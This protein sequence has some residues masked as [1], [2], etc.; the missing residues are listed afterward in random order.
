M[1]Q[2]STKFKVLSSDVKKSDDVFNK[3]VHVQ[4]VLSGQE[5]LLVCSHL[6]H[7]PVELVDQADW[8]AG[9]YTLPNAPTEKLVLG[10]H[11]QQQIEWDINKGE[12]TIVLT[13]TALIDDG[14]STSF[15]IRQVWV[16]KL[17]KRQVSKVNAIVRLLNLA[18]AEGWE[19][20]WV[21]YRYCD[22]SSN[23]EVLDLR[24][25]ILQSLLKDYVFYK[26]E[27]LT[28]FLYEMAEYAHVEIEEYDAV[29][30]EQVALAPPAYVIPQPA[31][32]Q[33]LAVEAQSVASLALSIA[34]TVAAIPV[35]F[36]GFW[37]VMVVG[38]NTYVSG[39]NIIHGRPVLEH[40]MFDRSQA[41][42]PDEA[43]DLGYDER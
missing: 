3:L 35:A 38:M 28:S 5:G 37:A 30:L 6:S 12:G 31:H 32:T 17:L 27:D 29:V 19:Q 11:P 22:R 26:Q 8:L 10:S 7:W 14:F 16:P 9:C 24:P 33:Q 2:H 34:A 43:I 13:V 40:T 1:F 39:D 42:Q 25:Y 21:V 18:D 36:A 15:L 20:F 4:H 23:Q 41:Q